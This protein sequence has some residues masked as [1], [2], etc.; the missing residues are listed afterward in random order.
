MALTH[1]DVAKILKLIDESR[2]DS[3][4]LEFGDLKLRVRKDGADAPIVERAPDT[5]SPIAPGA[6]FPDGVSIV[7]SPMVGTFYRASSPGERPF[8]EQGDRVAEGATVCLVEVM[9]L[10][11]SV[12]APCGGIIKEILVENATLVEYGQPLMLIAPLATE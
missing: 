3:V 12:T 5:T 6:A 11:S 9:K 7:R 2:F 8:V 4:D 1:D 10:F